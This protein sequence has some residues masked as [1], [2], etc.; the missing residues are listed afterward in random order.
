MSPML[1]GF[2]VTTRTFSIVL[3]RHVNGQKTGMRLNRMCQSMSFHEGNQFVGP[4]STPAD[5]VD[6][7]KLLHK[8][9]L[10]VHMKRDGQILWCGRKLSQ[11]Y[12]PWQEGDSDMAQL[13]VCQQCDKAQP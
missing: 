3:S 8:E 10:V 7:T 2:F 11:S 13:L 12:R 5:M 9:S 4:A 6:G 1:L